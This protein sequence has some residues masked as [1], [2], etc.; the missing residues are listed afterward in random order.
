MMIPMNRTVH[1]IAN[2]YGGTQDNRAMAHQAVSFIK[3]Q[4]IQVTLE[5]TE[6]KGHAREIAHSLPYSP[7]TTL[8]GLGGDG[9]MH[10]II[11]GIMHR[12]PDEQMPVGLLPG[13]TG[14]SF[15]EDMGI[16]NCNEALQR[17]VH[18]SYSNVDL[19][20]IN[21]DDTN[22]F[23]F[24]VCGW[25]LFASGN[26]TAESLRYFKKMRYHVAGLWEILRNRNQQAKLTIDNKATQACFSLIVASNTRNVGKSMLLSPKAECNDGKLDLLFLKQSGRLP[27]MRLFQKLP[28]GTHVHEPG[29]TYTQCKSYE[30]DSPSMT[31][32]NLDGEIYSGKKGK[33]TILPQAL[34]VCI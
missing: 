1:L 34:K 33:V 29:I 8:C 6:R 17:I 30:I 14:N 26:A 5:F 19:F 20:K 16:F 18:G 25:G 31:L 22:H 10:E 4:G 27:L 13:G 28:K 21:L 23:V 32:W 12:N 3:G 11:N 15:L 24:N 7:E 9:T 2:P